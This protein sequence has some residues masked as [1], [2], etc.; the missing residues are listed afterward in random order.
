MAPAE[1]GTESGR[2]KLESSKR[3][4][5][6]FLVPPDLPSFSSPHQTQQ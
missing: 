5:F 6:K 3:S 2:M 4:S 1:P